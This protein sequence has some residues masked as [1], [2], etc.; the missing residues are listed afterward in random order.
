[1]SFISCGSIVEYS[2]QNARTSTKAR[3]T[4]SDSES[5]SYV[6]FPDHSYDKSQI[7]YPQNQLEILTEKIKYLE[8]QNEALK[9][10]MS[11][12][13]HRNEEDLN[14]IIDKLGGL[15][16]L[17]SLS[18]MEFILKVLEK[19][20][21]DLQPS[22]NFQQNLNDFTPSSHKFRLE[23]NILNLEVDDL[24]IFFPTNQGE[25][26]AF[27]VG[28]PYHFLS[29]ESK[30][31]IN[32]NRDKFFNQNFVLGRIVLKERVLAIE[33]ESRYAVLAGSF[34]YT[35]SISSVTSLLEETSRKE[36]II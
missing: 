20:A 8:S 18:K 2:K 11:A 19:I 28:R 9:E 32:G 6:K 13:L 22:G 15:N 27:N 21:T 4:S 29:N 31:L 34:Y 3:V 36:T 12:I 35:V 25:F 17:G 16:L 23:I 33:D 24:V 14:S 10:S 1:M 26:A 5:G 30:E 7:S